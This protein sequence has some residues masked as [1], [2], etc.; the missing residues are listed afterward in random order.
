MANKQKTH[1]STG[2]LVLIGIV[3]ILMASIIAAGAFYSAA[4]YSKHSYQATTTSVTTTIYNSSYS[5]LKTNYSALSSS[6]N[7]VFAKYNG[8]LYNLSNPYTKVLYN[9]KQITVPKYVESYPFYNSEYDLYNNYTVQGTYNMTFSV[10]N[11]GYIIIDIQNISAVGYNPLPAIGTYGIQIFSNSIETYYAHE[12]KNVTCT[13][14]LYYGYSCPQSRAIDTGFS[15]YP[16]NY[17]ATYF[18]PVSRGQVNMSFLNGNNYPISVTFTVTYVGE[19][20]S[21]MTPISENY[22]PYNTGLGQG[23]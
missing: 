19:R 2:Q 7:S 17:S 3:G 8:I 22:S 5:S 18:A 23:G 4:Y 10:P 9:E 16:L 20:Y 11:D 13:Y 14:S 1:Y 6:Y 21:N 15:T 12:F